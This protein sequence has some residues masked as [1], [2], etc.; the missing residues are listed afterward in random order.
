MPTNH[1]A[2]VIRTLS[3]DYPSQTVEFF[4]GERTLPLVENLDLSAS[5]KA[6]YAAAQQEEYPEMESPVLVAT[7]DGMRMAACFMLAD[8]I[9]VD[10]PLIRRLPAFCLYMAFKYRTDRI[11]PVLIHQKAHPVHQAGLF[12]G[13][14]SCRWL[15]FTPVV[16]ALGDRTAASF[17]DSSNIV[18]Q[19][20]SPVLQH[21]ADER[22]NVVG[23]AIQALARLETDD[24]RR[25]RYVRFITQLAELSAEERRTFSQSHP[26]EEQWLRAWS[27][28][29]TTM[30]RP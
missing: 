8:A 25:S 17:R 2:E 20:L 11:L 29:A 22:L 21:P 12:L 24:G 16:C 3:R 27:T 15:S 19:V 13:D 26:D 5:Q 4:T 10:G 23:H 28:Q 18:A 14:E 7:A 30:P 1:L 6:A 9:D